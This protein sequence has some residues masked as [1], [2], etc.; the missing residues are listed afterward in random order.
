[1]DEPG[2][3]ANPAR[4]QLNRKNDIFLCPR[5]RLRMWSREM[6]LAGPSRASPLILQTQSES[7]AMGQ[8]NP[9]RKT[10]FKGKNGDSERGFVERVPKKRKFL[11]RKRRRRGRVERHLV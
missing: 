6:G 11:A 1:M 9:H 5:S 8:L 10:K 4:G 3:V 2:K 7:G